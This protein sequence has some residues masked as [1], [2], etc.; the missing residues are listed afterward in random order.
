MPRFQHQP[1]ERPNEQIRLLRILSC[2][3]ATEL[4]L[5]V[6][7]YELDC[8]PAYDALSYE[9]GEEH[10]TVDIFINGARFEIRHNLFLLLAELWRK[11][12][13]QHQASRLLWADAICINQNDVD[14]RNSQV[15]LMGDIYRK[16]MTVVAWLGWHQ[17][18][19]DPVLAMAFVAHLS[20]L[21]DSDVHQDHFAEMAKAFR[22]V[23]YFDL[24]PAI[25]EVFKCS[26]WHRRWII[27]ELV[28][29]Q[30]VLIL[31]G[32]AVFSFTVLARLLDL[33]VD[34]SPLTAIK[35]TIPGRIVK[36]RQS[37]VT[38]LPLLDVLY[39]FRDA[40]CEKV[41]DKVYS[42]LQVAKEG[43]V[44]VVDYNLPLSHLAKQILDLIGWDMKTCHLLLESL[45]S[46]QLS[47]FSSSLER[48]RLYH[49][50]DRGKVHRLCP[51]KDRVIAVRRNF[52]YSGRIV[53]SFPAVRNR[54]P[55]PSNVSGPKHSCFTDLCSRVEINEYLSD[56]EDQ[57]I[58]RDWDHSSDAV[59]L[60]DY[61][62]IGVA[63]GGARAGDLVLTESDLFDKKPLGCNG[64]VVTPDEY[65]PSELVGPI[66]VFERDVDWLRLRNRPEMDRKAQKTDSVTEIHSNLRREVVCPTALELLG[67][68]CY[69]ER[70]FEKFQSAI[71][72][73][74]EKLQLER[75]RLYGI[76]PTS[77]AP[78]SA[79]Q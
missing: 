76:T 71:R 42:L 72:T 19:A 46:S 8:V 48:R 56:P 17:Q 45:A 38:R 50:L 52:I 9:W 61:G 3:D 14:E 41:V 13:E 47:R 31:W 63:C 28:L 69:S 51:H 33:E 11:S 23:Y 59:F 12:E 74:Q 75:N 55:K 67:C 70:D 18:G 39:A 44:V 16:A 62:L 58:K 15:Q 30:R 1:L 54:A 57:E 78:A 24:L 49:W 35:S 4:R 6:A 53:D 36:L 29:G 20:S 43:S 2:E 66:A 32:K 77:P 26:Y 65:L 25:A 68:L 34:F 64:E 22:G 40:K 37:V 27:Q 5:S 21:S 79:G 7:T 60:T 73:V 10:P